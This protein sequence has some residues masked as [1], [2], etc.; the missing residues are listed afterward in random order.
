[1]YSNY[2]KRKKLHSTWHIKEDLME[3][4]KSTLK[5]A[6][7]KYLVKNEKEFKDEKKI[8]RN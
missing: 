1:M 8:F 4:R 2:I 6:V 7:F 5:Y 3:P